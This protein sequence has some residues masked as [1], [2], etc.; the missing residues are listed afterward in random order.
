VESPKPNCSIDSAVGVSVQ[1][2]W[3][4]N[5]QDR[6]NFDMCKLDDDEQRDFVDEVSQCVA[7]TEMNTHCVLN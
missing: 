3:V 6:V 4:L 7:N 5:F 1:R 2:I